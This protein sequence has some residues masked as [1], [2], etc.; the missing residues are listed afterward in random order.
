MYLKGKNYYKA[1]EAF[2]SGGR[3]IDAYI[4]RVPAAKHDYLPFLTAD[5]SDSRE[6]QGTS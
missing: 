2:C 4:V 1:F 6:G 5:L 3:V